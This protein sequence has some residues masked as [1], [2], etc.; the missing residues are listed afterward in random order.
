MEYLIESINDRDRPRLLEVWEASVRATHQFVSEEKIGHLKNLIIEQQYFFHSEIFCV[1]ND[2]GAI[3]GFAGITG[4]SLDMLF[5]HPSIIGTG[6]GKTLMQYAITVKGVSRVDVNEQ[7][8]NAREFYEHFGFE[9]T[10]R[11]ETDDNGEP[12]PLLHMMRPKQ[13]TTQ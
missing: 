13:I 10:G 9:V 12:F 5:L 8:K 7:N 2:T 1:R 3:A 11:S 4:D 6:A